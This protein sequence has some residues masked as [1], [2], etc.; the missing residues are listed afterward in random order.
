MVPSPWK[1][2]ALHCS[3]LLL[4]YSSQLIQPA[5][6]LKAE[7]W[8]DPPQ[9]IPVSERASRPSPRAIILF[10]I[11]IQ[12][13]CNGVPSCSGDCSGD[14]GMVPWGGTQGGHCIPA[15]GRREEPFFASCFLLVQ[16]LLRREKEKV[17]KP[18]PHGRS[19]IDL[20]ASG[21]R[22]RCCQR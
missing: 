6:P 19:T 8:T 1:A 18:S 16:E 9:D 11:G 14:C 5:P 12:S 2:Q 13:S 22:T 7:G 3:Y 15:T 20:R 17:S 10:C 21:V 4:R